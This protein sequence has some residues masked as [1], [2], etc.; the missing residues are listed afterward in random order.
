MTQT[1]QTNKISADSNN[2]VYYLSFDNT[3]Y[4]LRQVDNHPENHPKDNLADN[5]ASIY[6][7]HFDNKSTL[8]NLADGSSSRQKNSN[9]FYALLPPSPFVG[10][11]K[12]VL[13][14]TNLAHSQYSRPFHYFQQRA[15]TPYRI[16]NK[17]NANALQIGVLRTLSAR[18]LDAPKS[19]PQAYGIFSIHN[20]P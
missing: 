15:G 14:I 20:D 19:A 17:L 3:K 18:V 6:H 5:S 1:G 16:A 13:A 9:V 10:F 7:Y 11:C 2:S 12:P 8:K 4:S